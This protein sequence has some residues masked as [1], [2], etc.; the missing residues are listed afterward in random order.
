MRTCIVQTKRAG[1]NLIITLPK[2]VVVAEQIRPDAFVRITIEIV[3]GQNRGL[4][5]KEDN[6]GPDDPWRLLE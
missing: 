5:Q 1:D 3:Q 2:E 6:L 4:Q